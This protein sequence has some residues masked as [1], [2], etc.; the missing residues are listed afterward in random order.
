MPFQGIIVKVLHKKLGDRYYKKKAIVKVCSRTVV[1]FL[2]NKLNAAW[3]LGCGFE[4]I[5][6]K[7]RKIIAPFWAVS[8]LGFDTTIKFHVCGLL[9]FIVKFHSLFLFLEYSIRLF[10]RS[11]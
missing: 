10:C 7:Y 8:V 4:E 11:Q 3:S 2:G 5:S 6:G 9:Y 1:L